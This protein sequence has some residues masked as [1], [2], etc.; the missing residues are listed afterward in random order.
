MFEELPKR[1][2]GLIAADP[3]YRFRA[4]HSNR[5]TENRYPTMSLSG[6]KAL[7]VMDLAAENCALMLWTSPPFLK[8]SIEIM[9]AWKFRFVSIAFTWLKMKKH[10][11]DEFFKRAVQLYP[12]P[13]LELFSRQQRPG[14]TS[15]GNQTEKFE[16]AA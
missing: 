7:P 2:F 11:S 14:W 13:Y 5:S 6:I 1:H 9:A 10:H 15:W 4:G 12:G 8:E 3:P 16:A